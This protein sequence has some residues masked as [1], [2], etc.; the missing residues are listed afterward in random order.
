LW[1]GSIDNHIQLID[2]RNHFKAGKHIC[3]QTAP[4]K[5]SGAKDPLPAADTTQWCRK[6]ARPGG[7]A[8]SGME[9]IIVDTGI[10]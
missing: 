9:K 2:Y 4:K 8:V 6:P 5:K 10:E 7:L 1:I 3:D